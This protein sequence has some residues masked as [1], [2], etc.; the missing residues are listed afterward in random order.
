MRALIIPLFAR[1]QDWMVILVRIAIQR[2]VLD[3]HFTR[4]SQALRYLIEEDI[5]RAA[6]RTILQ[7]WRRPGVGI[8]QLHGDSNAFRSL[9]CY[10]PEVDQVLREHEA[11]LR[12]IFVSYAAPQSNVVS[13]T[14]LKAPGMMDIPEWLLVRVA[15]MKLLP[16]DG[17]LAEMEMD[18]PTELLRAGSFKAALVAMGRHGA[19]VERCLSECN[20]LRRIRRSICHAEGLVPEVMTIREPIDRCVQHLIEAIFESMTAVPLLAGAR[21]R[22]TMGLSENE[23]AVF[24]LCAAGRETDAAV[25]VKQGSARAGKGGASPA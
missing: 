7:V 15:T 17:D 22:S 2:Y 25:L 9:F 13:E 1:A 10:L 20:E 8:S 24:K 19:F 11:F 16:T 5:G 23:V 6:P 4:A 14:S 12:A 21:E 3:K 18:H